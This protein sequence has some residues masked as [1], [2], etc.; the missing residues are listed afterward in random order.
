MI[1]SLR[2]YRKMLHHALL[3]APPH[4]PRS[5][6]KETG[7]FLLGRWCPGRDILLTDLVSVSSG[8][9]V[10]VSITDPQA[11]QSIPFD[12]VESGE[13]IVGWWHTHP[14]LRIFM[15]VTDQQTQIRYQL[16]HPNTVALVMDPTEIASKNAGMKGFQVANGSR[17]R[18]IE[19]PLHFEEI[20]DF[21]ET[22]QA[23]LKEISGP[24]IPKI[25]IMEPAVVE[26]EFLRLRIPQAVQ[27]KKEF[28]F[29]VSLKSTRE[30]KTDLTRVRYCLGLHKLKLRSRLLSPILNHEVDEA[31]LLAQF[32]IV[33]PSPG[34]ARVSLTGILLQNEIG[35]EVS[36]KPMQQIVTVIEEQDK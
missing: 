23:V 20:N 33:A 2:V 14:G 19:M 24:P 3:A 8:S 22:K 25:P 29:T 18:S 4:K 5:T 1:I 32:R 16:Q 7:G 26:N 34:T 31:G 30:P 15:S 21:F 28:T 17:P 27:I 13:P 9:S 10:F 35:R 11:T 6:W 36:L 12:R